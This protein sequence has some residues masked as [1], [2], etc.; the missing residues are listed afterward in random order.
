MEGATVELS[1][2]VS[3]NGITG[4]GGSLHFEG[5]P[6]GRYAL[7]ISFIGFKTV[8]LNQLSVESG[9]ELVVQVEL[10]EAI[11]TH[12][13]VVV[14]RRTNRSRAI[15]EMAIVSSRMFSVEE[16]RRFAAGLNDPSRI[17]T[18]FAGVQGQGDGNGLVVRGNAPNGL[19]WRMEGVDIPNPNHFARVGTSGGA[20]S[21]LSA[22]MLAN[23]DFLTGAF[24]AEYGSALSGVF[25]IRLRK[26]NQFKKEHTFSVS[27]IGIDAATEG[28][29]K[30]GKNASYLMNYRYGFLT[31]M[32]KMGIQIGDAATFFQ[33]F[34]FHINVPTQKW[35]QFSV[36]GFGGNSAQERLP[37]N[38]S[39]TWAGFPS[40]R[41]GWLDAA[42]T[43]ALAFTHQIKTGKRGLLKTVYSK[44][45]YEYRE[46]DSRLDK[47]PGPLVF[48]RKNRFTETGDVISM[49]YTRKFSNKLV[50]KS[51]VYTRRRQFDLQ[52]RETVSNQLR[53]KIKTSGHTWQ[54][55]YFS[56]WK[57]DPSNRL[58]ITGGMHA[59]RLALNNQSVLEPRFGI[60]WATGKNSYFTTGIGRHAQVQPLGNYFARI[61]VGNDTVQPNKQLKFS[62]AD[63]F[64]AGFSFPVAAN[65]NV[66]TEA[67]YQWLFD[68]PVSASRL[69]NFSMINQEDDF[70]I[71]A[72]ANKGNGK[73]YGLELT[74]EKYRTDQFYLLASLSLYQSKY[75]PSDKLWRNTR[76]NSKTIF[77]LAAGKEWMFKGPKRVSRFS[78][79]VKFLYAGGIRVTPIDL[80]KSIAQKTTVLDTKRWLEAQLKPVIRL[81]LQL[82]WKVHYGARTGSLIAG[83]Q[84]VMNR[85]N[86]VRHS[87]NPSTM[88]IQYSYLLGFIPVFGY[89]VDL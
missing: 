25:D 7:K 44:N 88:Q 58:T 26:G 65:W 41:S 66:K 23:S 13:E 46:E 76:Y 14:Q 80:Q 48:S 86:Q 68:I 87:Y 6:V 47:F 54:T 37:T 64:V 69:S 30:K 52:Q 45:G 4:S 59:Q 10:E 43:G 55:H 79:D 85:K 70:A 18:A 20:I 50:M 27:S 56:Q 2:A 61:R 72:L 5:V 33:D 83:A 36:F 67:Y 77:S 78:A 16:T 75:L 11:T 62:Q 28:Y 81:D 42:K 39:L 74:V 63:H 57:W 31:L 15:N 38:D 17:A 82:E 9:K 19:L 84:N 3:R 89:K 21:I 51:G 12:R 71:E 35:G 8:T 22:Q 29:F 40:K 49:V 73:N 53:D 1:G 60:R 24:P 34:S 32:Q